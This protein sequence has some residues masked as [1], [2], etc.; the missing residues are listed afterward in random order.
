MQWNTVACISTSSIKLFCL[1]REVLNVK[2][3]FFKVYVNYILFFIKKK[4]IQ[5]TILGNHTYLNSHFI[6]NSLYRKHVH[7][8]K[9]TIFLYFI[10]TRA[11]MRFSV[12]PSSHKNIFQSKQTS[13]L[14]KNMVWLT[15]PYWN[16]NE[17]QTLWG[18]NV[19]QPPKSHY[20]N[21]MQNNNNN[22]NNIYIYIYMYDYYYCITTL[23]H[24]NI[25]KLMH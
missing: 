22:N 12:T 6:L 10:L 13:A 19:K 3:A 2:K 18:Q 20:C 4:S 9:L 16:N 5:F 23:M 11:E 17:S 25:I 14:D 24:Y 15:R 1:I 21:A 7:P 8:S